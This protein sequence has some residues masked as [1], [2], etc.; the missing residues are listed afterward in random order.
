MK[1]VHFCSAITE[2]KAFRRQAVI[3]LFFRNPDKAKNQSGS[4]NLLDNI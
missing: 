2:N 4:V 1:F 3:I